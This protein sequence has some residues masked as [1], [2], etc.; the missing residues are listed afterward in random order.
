TPGVYMA[1]YAAS[2]QGATAGCADTA[3]VQVVV[4]PSPTAQF[5][6]SDDAACDSLTVAFT[7]TSIN[8]V[9]HFW[10]LGDGTTT[11][12]ATPPPHHYGSPG[13]YV[14]SLTVTNAL[15]CTDTRTDTVHVFD[16]PQVG[17]GAQDVCF[18]QPVQFLDQT[19]TAALNPVVQWAW[20][21]GDGGTDTV[22]DPLHTFAAAG[23]YTVSLIATTLHCSGSGTQN[24]LVEAP[25]VA[26]FSP[27]VVL[28]CTPLDVNFTNT[29]TGAVSY[30]WDFGDGSTSSQTTPSHSF[31][32]NGTAD[33]TFT[34]T[35]VASTLFGCSDT[36]V[37]SITVTPRA[38]A[39]FSHN[40]TPGCAPL[41][42]DFTNLSTGAGSYFWDFGD[43]GTST[44]PNPSHGY[45]NTSFFLDIHTVTLVA[46]S[47]AGC[48]DTT[49]QQI[50][51]F[52]EPN[53]SFV[54]E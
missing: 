25:P 12:Q 17:I 14:V 32:N 8:A 50:T 23:A 2:I 11:N 13:D 18:G 33:S 35:L 9:T 30:S 54:T 43:G 45:T 46:I 19:Q 10:D 42:V 5:V 21:F 34:V 27:D 53:F 7:N 29:S 16:P 38:V 28:G 47:P 31:V 3:S 37:M 1:S 26:A 51:V 48:S 22:Q 52:P 15:G 49:T 4:L 40:A 44:L 20:D 6:L 24:V 36:T 41:D 39:Q